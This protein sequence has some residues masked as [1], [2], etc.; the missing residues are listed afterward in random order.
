LTPLTGE[1][2][3]IKMSD[4]I[5]SQSGAASPLNFIAVLRQMLKTSDKVSDLIFSPGRPP[6]I[7][8]AGKLLPVDV[9]GL[10]KLTP[11]HTASIA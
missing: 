2:F 6:Q 9:P 10:G 7:E 1:K 3:E 5:P 8:L 11:A 4:P